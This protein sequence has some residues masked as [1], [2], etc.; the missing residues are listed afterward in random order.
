MQDAS[1]AG[2]EGPRVTA[3]TLATYLEDK[4]AKILDV[5]CGSGLVGEQ[6]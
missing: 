3:E 6:V 4:E 1:E 2:Y 5:G